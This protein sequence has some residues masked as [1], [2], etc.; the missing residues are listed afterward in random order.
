MNFKK[1]IILEN[2]LVRLEPLTM[3]HFNELLPIALKTPDLLKFSPSYFGDE[4]SLKINIRSAIEARENKQRYAFCIYDKSKARYIGCSS[5]GNISTQNQRLEIGWTWIG[6]DSQGRGLNQQCKYLLLS[7]AFDEL[8][9]E[10]V[11]FRTDSRNVQ[12]RKALEKIGGIYE[13][14]LRSHTLM[15]DGYRRD[16][17]YYGILKSDWTRLKSEKF[18][19]SKAYKR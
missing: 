16:T 11:E 2:D 7:Y 5:F 10:R 4:K 8:G 18:D 17:A 19:Q 14:T 13:G 15:I 9:I 3:I 12:S 1:S 6:K